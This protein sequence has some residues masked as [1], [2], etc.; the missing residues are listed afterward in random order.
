MFRW[1]LVAKAHTGLLAGA[2]I[3]V[4]HSKVMAWSVSLPGRRSLWMRGT[5]SRNRFCGCWDLR[6]DLVKIESKKRLLDVFSETQRGGHWETLWNR[7]W[8]FV[9]FCTLR[10]HKLEKFQSSMKAVFNWVSNMTLDC[11]G[12]SLLCSVIG[13]EKLVP[14]SQPIKY[15]TKTNPI[16]VTR[17]SRASSRLPVLTWVL[18]D[19]NLCSD[20]LLRLLGFWF[21]DTQLLWLI[22]A[23]LKNCIRMWFFLAKKIQRAVMSAVL[24][25]TYNLHSQIY[26]WKTYWLPSPS[27]KEKKGRKNIMNVVLDKFPL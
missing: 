4:G 18:I 23:L 9:H 3:R 7:C 21:W 1:V 16:F 5:Y 8:C 22:P 12:F 24:F 2:L 13:P 20:W 26:C 6:Q 15:K 27:R 10:Q 11:F 14:P 25:I 17:V 19:V